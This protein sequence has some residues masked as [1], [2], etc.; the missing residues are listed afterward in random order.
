MSLRCA[1]CCSVLQFVVVCC[2]VLPAKGPNEP[3]VCSVLQCVAVCCSVLQCV[4]VYSSVLQCAAVC[5]SVLQCAAV[6]C[7]V[8]QC[9]AVFSSRVESGLSRIDRSLLQ[10]SPIKETIFCN[11]DLQFYRSYLLQCSLR[12]CNGIVGEG[13]CCSVL[14]CVAVCCSVLQCSAV[15]CSVLQ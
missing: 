2:S 11:R 4:A 14:Q 6:C 3:E 15:C 12:E 1:V 8:L 10:K 9:V 13:V 7:S 5:C